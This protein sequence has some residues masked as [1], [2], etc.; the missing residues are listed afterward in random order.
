MARRTMK[1]GTR[2]VT[3]SGFLILAAWWAGSAAPTAGQG[4][5]VVIKLATLAPSGSVWH[6]I[7]LDMGEQWSRATQGEVTLR[8]YPGGVAGE[9][10]DVLRKM[11][12]GQLH[13]G[14]LSLAGLQRITPWVNVLAI[15]MLMQTPED[16][17]RVRTAMEPRLEKVFREKGYVLLNWGDV[18]WMRYFLPTPDVSIEACRRLK[19]VAWSDDAMLELWR[20]EGFQNVVLNLSD[21][22]PGLQ[23]GLVDAIGS[24]PLWV[25]SNQWFPFV[26][27]MLDMPWAPL[28]GA[29]VIDL[30]VWDRI[31]AEHRPALM[32]IAQATGARFQEETQRKEAEAIAAMEARGLEVVR[33]TPDIIAEWRAL[34][35][36]AYPRLRGELIPA[37]WF[38]AAVEA[39]NNREGA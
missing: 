37:D 35:E 21:V 31:P 20:D 22:L 9:E 24:T 25:I 18:G 32:R 4:R 12:I 28:V 34:F 29:T 38:D 11:R 13:A 39:A 33:P 16:L 14:S 36:S 5:P 1:N 23:T 26:P 15:P 3:L 17:I 6:E 7:L 10:A 30:K 2:R 8:I 27:Y 19:F